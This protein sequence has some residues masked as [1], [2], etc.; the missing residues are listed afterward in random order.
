MTRESGASLNELAAELQEL[1]QRLTAFKD[2]AKDAHPELKIGIQSQIYELDEKRLHAHDAI[3][4]LSKAEAD[5]LPLADQTAEEALT[6]LRTA[7]E[8]A[9]TRFE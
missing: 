4:K 7:I 8:V 6:D 5:E 1:D 2:R 9:E 3:E